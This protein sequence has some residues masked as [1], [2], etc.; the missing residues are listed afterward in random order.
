M[1]K[2]TNSTSSRTTT[3]HNPATTKKTTSDKI[4]RVSNDKGVVAN[5][6]FVAVYFCERQPKKGTTS[7]IVTIK[8]TTELQPSP[9]PL[10]AAKRTQSS[11]ST[12]TPTIHTA[13]PPK[14]KQ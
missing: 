4:K 8:T 1:D 10:P 12:T 14:Q 5:D 13:T 3:C 7:S 9:S 2:D 11:T 6:S